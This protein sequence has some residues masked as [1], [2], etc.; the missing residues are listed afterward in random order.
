MDY[1]FD[2]MNSR[3]FEHMIQALTQ[4]ILGSSSIIFGDGPDGGREATFNGKA[5]YPNAIESWEGYWVVQA[6]YKAKNDSSDDYNWL[7]KQFKQEIQSF[8]SRKKSGIKIPDN[9]LFFTN[10][11]ITGVHSKGI[12][13]KIE[14]I[15]DTYR[16][17][18]SNISIFGESDLRGFLD[19]NRD[20]AT[21]YSSF[22]LPG[23]ILRKLVDLIDT[24]ED[25]KHTYELLARFLENEYRGDLTSRLEQA[26]RITN[27]EIRLDDVF[28]DLYANDDGIRGKQQI[29]ESDKFVHKM[30]RLSNTS[31]RIQN[32]TVIESDV[33]VPE[34][35][36]VL[37]GGP[38]YGKSTATQYLC[39]VY[40]AYFL[41]QN[42]VNV[43]IDDEIASF[44]EEYGKNNMNSLDCVRF[45]FKIV[46]KDYAG[47]I[48]DR[49]KANNNYS[50]ISYLQHNLQKKGDDLISLETIRELL[51]NL[52]LLFIFDGLDE[53]PSTSNRSLVLDEI[54]HFIYTELRRIN[55]D[56]LI[57]A[58]TRP[59][60]YTKEFN[61][62]NFKHLYLTDLSISESLNYFEKL[63]VKMEYNTEIRENC[64]SM[65]K[66]AL[67]DTTLSSLMKSPLQTTIMAIL[68][69]TG[70]EP[71]RSRYNLF[72]EYYQ[73]MFKRELQK[74]V[75]KILNEQPEIVNSIHNRLGYYL[76]ANSEGHT[77]PSSSLT[78]DE[79][80][81][82]TSDVL[83]QLHINSELI[84]DFIDKL[85]FALIER[86]VFITE[87]EDGKVGFSI[88]S[89]QE[90]FAAHYMLENRP[91]PDI[92][93]YLNSLAGNHY[94]RNTFLFAMGY[95]YKHKNYLL[96][97][98][99][100]I[101]GRLNGQGDTYSETTPLKITK[102][103]SWLA[104][105]ILNESIFRGI[106]LYENMFIYYLEELFS[107]PFV[108]EHAY[109]SSLPQHIKEVCVYSL[110]QKIGGESIAFNRTL[111]G[112][113]AYFLKQED[114][115]I[116]TILDG[117]WPKND[118]ETE[119]SLLLFLGE[120]GLHDNQWFCNKIIN[121]L[122]ESDFLAYK[123]ILIDEDYLKN[124]IN[125]NM[126]KKQRSIILSN[127]IIDLLKPYSLLYGSEYL[128][129][130]LKTLSNTNLDLSKYKFGTR[131]SIF[132]NSISINVTDSLSFNL[133][134]LESTDLIKQ[135]EQIMEFDTESILF[136]VVAYLNNPIKKNMY[137]LFSSLLNQP[138]IVYEQLK[139]CS[140]NFNWMI[141]NL[142]I[143]FPT[144]ESIT[145]LLKSLDDMQ[146]DL[147]DWIIIEENIRENKNIYKYSP[148]YLTHSYLANNFLRLDDTIDYKDQK[149]KITSLNFST[150]LLHRLEV[151]I[152]VTIYIRLRK[153][154][155]F[156]A[157]LDD[158]NIQVED[159]ILI[160]NRE[161]FELEFIAPSIWQSIITNT[162]VSRFL[163]L[164]STIPSMKIPHPSEGL[165]FDIDDETETT[166][167]KKASQI[168][169]T[170]T[171][172]NKESVI[173]R[174]IAYFL[175]KSPKLCDH[176]ESFIDYNYLTSISYNDPINEYS[177]IIICANNK[178]IWEGDRAEELIQSIVNFGD[179][180]NYIH[181]D[182]TR[183]IQHF[184]TGKDD[185]LIHILCSLY[186]KVKN[187]DH[188]FFIIKDTL[189]S[190]RTEILSL[191]K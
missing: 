35:K 44:I 106:P 176:Q 29:D 141:S 169:M 47:W 16:D 107:L 162:E 84:E 187:R 137:D 94:W 181:R 28:I 23:D 190:Q 59:Q 13:D 130:F 146:E 150:E 98:V 139:D 5:K 88:R 65:I 120:I 100:S 30:I 63:F 115:T 33:N 142:M 20:V 85:S 26:G 43:P 73:T 112:V 117:L 119:R 177:R 14:K 135:L 62:S 93:R 40:R 57:I 118:K 64:I 99:H 70:G 175:L 50:V 72:Y 10:I 134:L 144:S 51:K 109:I 168:L 121:A 104:L 89:I 25:K 148:Q 111:W 90:F 41:M 66:T 83:Q 166:T 133:N 34:N 116:E 184:L 58:T 74:G 19:N 110:I 77:A 124:I 178:S 21:T 7:K 81:S 170:F 39:Q 12:R 126:S 6:K 86:L 71:P 153:K 31:H 180:N 140:K 191:V 53:V 129:M 36:I 27:E 183:V 8:L 164:I 103:G 55:S 17:E 155:S 38:G 105:D 11:N 185:S 91:D 76:Q 165:I 87:V 123:S 147:E 4:K 68:V 37:I 114:K 22:I 172:A 179:S 97:S 159:I 143:L 128:E 156:K 3:D 122:S 45:P 151:E 173:I 1:R 160:L 186:D 75:V 95:L 108:D 2:R 188:Y 157:I 152:L 136:K 42:Y 82:F 145:D 167:F 48:N 52:S 69:K 154:E 60:G 138:P 67:E 171:M 189:L 46:L 56:S 18:I 113:S 49:N 149:E 15:A 61:P 101:C 78:F 131:E 54:N 102:L 158:M 132:H 80:K 96:Q 32:D 163:E 79:F 24:I 9:Y 174:L 125:L 182:V 92:L 161:E 127:I